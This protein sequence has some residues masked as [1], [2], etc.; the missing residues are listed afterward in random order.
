MT[1]ARPRPPRVPEA[2]FTGAGYFLPRLMFLNARYAPQLHWGDVAVALDGFA[3]E[4]DLGSAAFWVEW[5]E[6]WEAQAGRWEAV[7]DRAT[8]AAGRSRALR[9]AAACHHWAEFMYFDDAAVKLRLRQRIRELTRQALAGGELDISYGE[10][11][12]DEPCGPRVPY[13]LI[14]PPAAVRPAGPL[15]CVILS[16]G[17]DSVT[18]VEVLSLAEAYLER[19]I[20]ALLFDGPGQGVHVGQVPLRIE[21]ESVVARLL[22]VVR[23]DERIDA[24]RLGFL[25]VSFGGYLALRVAQELGAEFRCVVNLSGGPLIAPFEGLP[26]R[27]KDDFRFALGCDDDREIQARFDKLRIDPAARPATEV[28]SVH[29]AL[30]DIFPLA[31][32]ADLD[33]AWGAGHRLVVHEREAH[34]C[35]NLINVCSLDAADWVAERLLPPSTKRNP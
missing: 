23:A 6:R 29:G 31:A 3:A 28:L 35:L 4:V 14:L 5:L 20:A 24:G 19:G 16:N 21:M 18:E 10:L 9:S 34:V 17:L 22:E 26:R 11:E 33:E 13:Q 27:L 12:P 1:T 30:D 8:T 7:A 25:G 32:L 15:A 2:L